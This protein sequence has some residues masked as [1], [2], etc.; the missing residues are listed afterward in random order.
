MKY[1]ENNFFFLKLNQVFP[2]QPLH[3]VLHEFIIG[4]FT[5]IGVLNGELIFLFL[6]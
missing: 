5:N 2:K 4:D 3:F 1:C 6:L